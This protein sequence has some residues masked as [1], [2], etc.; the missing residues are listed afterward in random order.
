MSQVV[1]KTI[2]YLLLTSSLLVSVACQSNLSNANLEHD[3]IITN[4]NESGAGE[5]LQT[6]ANRIATI[7]MRNNLYSLY[8]LLDKFYKRN[9]KQWRKIANSSKEAK[10][11]VYQS[12]EQNKPFPGLNNK[13]SIDALYIALD[14]DFTGDRVGALIYGMATMIIIAHGNHTKFYIS[15]IVNGEHVFNAA[16]NVDIVQWMLKQRKD[17]K[18]N[19]LLVSNEISDNS[20]NLS[21]AKELAKI[22]ARLDLVAAVL[23]ERYRRVGVNYVH[24]LLFL[25]FFPVQ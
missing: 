15:D 12:I 14:P 5:L 17:H 11:I 23:D 6:D 18:G 4:S 25:T 10:N 8:I 13:N 3:E 20:Y 2:Q 1:L 19:P 22:T 24:N 9:P 16:R 7:A 21:F